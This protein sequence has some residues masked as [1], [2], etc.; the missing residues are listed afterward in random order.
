MKNRISMFESNSA[1][2]IAENSRRS[3]SFK[4]VPGKGLDWATDDNA[5]H[6][7]INASDKH[8]FSLNGSSEK[9]EKPVQFSAPSPFKRIQNQQQ[10]QTSA[11]SNEKEEKWQR[12]TDKGKEK[13]RP[14]VLDKFP[15]MQKV[16]SR[17]VNWP[18]P[19]EAVE[20]RDEPL[21]EE[22][23]NENQVPLQNSQS[24]R[25]RGS[26]EA[27]K[28]VMEEEK[29]SA[30]SSSASSRSSLSNKELSSIA[31]RALALSKG[32]APK[33]T[34]G[35]KIGGRL[36]RAGKLDRIRCPSPKAG[37]SPSSTVQKNVAQQEAR[38]AL[39][40]AAQRKK[41]R[42]VVSDGKEISQDQTIQQRESEVVER[43][44]FKAS[45][46]LSM[47]KSY[48]KSPLGDNIQQEKAESVVSTHS[49]SSRKS[50][51]SSDPVWTKPKESQAQEKP[52]S[53]ELVTSF[54]HFNASRIPNEVENENDTIILFEGSSC[55]GRS[56]PTGKHW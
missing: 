4:S 45:R 12:T 14:V 34:S 20:K 21:G 52:F 39:L 13:R 31:V 49:M 27:A 42:E 48:E 16:E 44:G 11:N 36:S 19:A 23:I 50:R 38:L 25:L 8:R 35:V 53:E 43:L 33:E 54:R 7:W 29:S 40:N 10:S 51:K 26:L 47:K 56:S 46:V 28:V 1:A 17:E 37:A 5:N 3:S 32:P 24:R 30:G 55:S 41:E 2:K 9:A 6:D 15:Y 22:S 18:K